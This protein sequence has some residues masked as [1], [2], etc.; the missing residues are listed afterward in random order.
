[1]EQSTS[2]LEATIKV[3]LMKNLLKGLQAISEDCILDFRETGLTVH[4]V[5]SL[6]AK[7]LRLRV[8]PEGFETYECDEQHRLAVQLSKIKDIT[9]SLTAKDQ[10]KLCYD[11]GKFSLVANDMERVIR[12]KRL[13]LVFDLPSMPSFDYEYNTQIESAKEVKDYLKTLDKIPVFRVNIENEEMI[14]RT[15]DRDEEISWSP[16]L[17][18]ECDEEFDANQLFTTNQVLDLLAATN[19]ET[20]LVRGGENSCPLEFSWNPTE[21]VN[22]TGLVAPR[23]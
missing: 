22:F 16:N 2:M 9:K 12:L 7:M 11:D 4:I 19:K 17:E 5:D 15:L 13:E 6:R 23:V 20:L 3:P 21:G 14:W 10:L 18:L 1:M 8:N